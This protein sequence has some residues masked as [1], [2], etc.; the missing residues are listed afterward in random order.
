MPPEQRDQ[1]PSCDVCGRTILKGERVHEYVTQQG[2]RVGVCSLC[3][4]RAESSGWIAAERYTSAAVAPQ[5]RA[6]RGEALRSALGRAASRARQ[7]A[8]ARR[9][10]PQ[11][12]PESGPDQAA[13]RPAQ[14]PQRPAAKPRQRAARKPK[15][16]PAQPEPSAPRRR[17]GPEALM[18]KAVERFNTSDEVRK[19]A[20]LIRSLGAPRAAVTP[21]PLRQSALVTVAWELSWYQWE[22]R[23]NGGV[24]P[25]REIAKGDEVSELSDEARVW[26]AAVAE[27][28]SLRLRSA[29]SSR[30][31]TEA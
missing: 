25:V 13:Q 31:Q 29:S 27:D 19:V 18:R 5:N 14:E 2:E 6:R 9:A 22:I 4:T 23:D 11:A 15:A 12:E 24:D 1:F 10:T 21:D 28:G 30:Q 8:Q 20:G 7:T 26:N 16:E 3:R 17:K